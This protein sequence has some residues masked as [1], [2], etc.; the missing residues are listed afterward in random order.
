MV[1]EDK[2]EIVKETLFQ[3]WTDLQES[4]FSTAG[5]QIRVELMLKIANLIQN[6]GEKG[7]SKLSQS[8]GKMAEEMFVNLS[9]GYERDVRSRT[10]N[11]SKLCEAIIEM[12]L[13][14]SK[15]TTLAREVVTFCKTFVGEMPDAL[16]SDPLEK[17]ISR[18]IEEDDV[19]EAYKTVSWKTK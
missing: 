10:E 17:Y 6:I 1:V 4:N 9:R 8:F 7:D 19:E 11:D 16:S 15:S 3:V 13:Y 5:R 2:F 12:S 18:M 14:Y